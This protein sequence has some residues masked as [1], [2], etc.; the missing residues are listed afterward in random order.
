M[1]EVTVPV[2]RMRRVALAKVTLPGW[3]GKGSSAG[4]GGVTPI[5]A[6]EYVLGLENGVALLAENGAKFKLEISN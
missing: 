6:P 1:R 2:V 4:G 5:E 3:L